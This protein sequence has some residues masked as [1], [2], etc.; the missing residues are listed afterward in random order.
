MKGSYRPLLVTFIAVAAMATARA[1]TVTF[2][3]DSAPQGSPLP[4]DLTVGGITAHLSSGSPFYNYSIQR[5][6][7][8]GFTPVGF[9]GLCVYPSTVFQSDLQVSFDTQLQDISVLYAPEEYATDSS[10]TMRITAYAGSTL[11]GTATYQIPVPG[12]WPTGTL[13][14]SSTQPFDNVVIHYDSPPPTGGD[15][16]PIFM[17][18]NMVVTPYGSLPTVTMRVTDGS[19]S[20]VPSTDIGKVRI[21]RTGDLTSA[22]TVFYTVGGTATSGTDYRAL[23]GRASIKTGAS[24]VV[25]AIRPIDDTIP[26]PDETVILVLSPNASYAIGSPGSGRVRIHSN[27]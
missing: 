13:A 11:V 4:I 9:S 21:T 22:L 6:D 19:A 14:F 18:D 15:Y 7:V 10:C 5:A 8:L 17:V 27:E 23:V 2:D 24:S 12:T 26:E 25:V 3:F 1:Q 20:E 16:G